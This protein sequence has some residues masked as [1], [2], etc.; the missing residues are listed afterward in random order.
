MAAEGRFFLLEKIKHIIFVKNNQQSRK[1]EKDM[2]RTTKKALGTMIG[3]M[4]QVEGL[5]GRQMHIIDVLCKI[6][7]S[8][9]IASNTEYYY[10]DIDRIDEF[11]D[12]VVE[13]DDEIWDVF[14]AC[15]TLDESG[16]I[17]KLVLLNTKKLDEVEI[18]E[19]SRIIVNFK[20][21]CGIPKFCYVRIMYNAK[22]K[23][24]NIVKSV[25][26]WNDD[27][28]ACTFNLNEVELHDKKSDFFIKIPLN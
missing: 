28:D 4:L 7:E 16:E 15:K 13:N 12:F 14:N 26:N 10:D 25:F 2:E 8:R 5:S 21:A 9:E 6:N 11:E 3:E 1:E 22:N 17:T 27:V 18:E 20:Y 24:G 19:D 23:E